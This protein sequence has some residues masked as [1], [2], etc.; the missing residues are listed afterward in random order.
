MVTYLHIIGQYTHWRI[1]Q[2]KEQKEDTAKIF[3]IFKG[4][5]LQTFVDDKLGV[6]DK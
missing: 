2:R 4:L 1:L 3:C 6:D 5:G